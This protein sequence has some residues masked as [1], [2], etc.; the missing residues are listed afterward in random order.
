MA[1]KEREPESEQGFSCVSSEIA[2]T[3][4]F[5]NKKTGM[6]RRRTS[7]HYTAGEKAG[8]TELEWK[9]F[10]KNGRSAVLKDPT[11]IASAEFEF[12]KWSKN[13]LASGIDKI[14][15]IF[16]KMKPLMGGRI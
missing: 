2:T 13:E 9:A 5:Y 6:S 12:Y 16:A 4:L 14:L 15:G 11:D 3:H 7:I 1:K 10:D 8:R